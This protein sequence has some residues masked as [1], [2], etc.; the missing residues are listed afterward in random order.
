MK[1][2]KEISEERTIVRQLEESFQV[3]VCSF[4]RKNNDLTLHKYFPDSHS[5][6]PW[7]V[8][9]KKKNYQISMIEGQ[10]KTAL[11]KINRWLSKT[12]VNSGSLNNSDVNIQ[13]T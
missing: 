11:D 12:D 2:K 10:W 4:A 3:L 5:T 1:Q 7:V 6:K 13:F 8:Y 9:N